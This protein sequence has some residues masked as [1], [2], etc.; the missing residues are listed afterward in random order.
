MC[1][2]NK[3]PESIE[4]VPP[5]RPDVIGLQSWR[6][7]VMDAKGLFGEPGVAVFEAGKPWWSDE[8]H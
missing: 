2:P 1:K 6:L 4:A 7:E 8:Q 5:R 3:C